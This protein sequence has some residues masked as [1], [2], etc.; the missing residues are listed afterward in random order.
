VPW[1]VPWDVMPWL[2]VRWAVPVGCVVGGAV[3]GE[4]LAKEL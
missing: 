4:R 1:A 2:A 3:G